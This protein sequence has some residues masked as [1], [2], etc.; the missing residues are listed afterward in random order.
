MYEIDM[1][2]KDVLRTEYLENST[3]L[4]LYSHGVLRTHS[5]STIVMAKS[6]DV[7]ENA[8]FPILQS[9]DFDKN[10]S[11]HDRNDENIENTPNSLTV[12]SLNWEV[13]QYI[14]CERNETEV[15]DLIQNLAKIYLQLSV[16]HFATESVLQGVMNGMYSVFDSCKAKFTELLFHSNL[17]DKDNVSSIFCKSFNSF[18]N[19]HDPKNGILRSTFT[20]KQYYKKEY[21]F[22]QPIEVPILDDDGKETQCYFSYVPVLETIKTWLLNDNVRPFCINPRKSTTAQ[23]LFDVKDGNV[24]KN[25]EFFNKNNTVQLSFYQDAFEV[26]NPLG[27]SKSKFKLI[28]VYVTLLNLPAFLRSKTD[29]IKLIM[30]C[31]NNF[32]TKFGWKK[33]L[34]NLLLDLHTLENE[35]INITINSEHM[36]FTGSIAACIGDNLGNHSIGGY[37]ENFSSAQFIC[38]YCEIMLKDFRENP[39]DRKQ[40]RNIANYDKHAAEAEYL[41]KP[42]KGI[43]MKSSLNQLQNFHVAGPGLAPCVAHDL[44]EG[45]VSYDLH[46]IITYFIKKKW[47]RLGLLNYRLNT[48]KLSNETK[49]FIPY[50]K[51]NSTKKN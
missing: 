22:I 10:K 47:V 6:N 11:S 35:G 26:C 41:K 28:G 23:G 4:D 18:I 33:I 34:R 9:I 2:H 21:N 50:I 49:N 5:F 48:I 37:V 32:V 51:I 45:I 25:S 19:S 42:V 16:K 7:L 27:A 13:K 14:S 3:V 24:I 15:V 8:D 31:N 46:L 20:R 36:K 29:N 43:K 30:L 1:N 12:N 39:F 17:N 44:F 38:Q 40:L